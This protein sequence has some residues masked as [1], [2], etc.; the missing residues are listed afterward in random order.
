MPEPGALIKKGIAKLGIPYTEKQ[1]H[2]FITY[3][4]ELKKWN[5]AQNLTGL[6]TDSDIIIKHF[7]DSLLFFKVLP[8]NVKTVADI[9]SG[10]GFP[11]I[12]LKIINPDLEVFLIEPTKK[13]V[14]FLRHISHKLGL[15]GIE[16]ID[17]RL[18]DIEGLRVDVAV[19]RALFSIRE[20]YEKAERIINDKGFLL[21]NKGPKF[22][23]ELKGVEIKNI[24]VKEFKLPFLNIMR[25]MIVVKI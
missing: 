4:D 22:E 15:Q 20:F 13:K 16:V 7:L 21:L 25:Y 6:K 19:T 8:E 23:D 1:I 2:S 5:K 11:G 3:L 17:N 24:S 14:I 10:A 9:G 18:E 12:P